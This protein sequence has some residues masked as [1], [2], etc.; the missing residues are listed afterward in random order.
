[1][2]QGKDAPSPRDV[3][4]LAVI[5]NHLFASVGNMGTHGGKLLQGIKGFQVLPVFKY[6]YDLGFKREVGHSFLRE[7]GPDDV[8]GD[9]LHGLLIS[10][11]NPGAAM[12]VESGMPPRQD[13]LD[14]LRDL[15]FSQEHPK[16]FM[17]MLN[18]L[19]NI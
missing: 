4:A 11:L 1:M 16:D 13:E 14:H 18:I 6:V 15:T 7:R 12:D 9:V 3:T 17:L 8:S 19:A 5:P 10:G 2:C